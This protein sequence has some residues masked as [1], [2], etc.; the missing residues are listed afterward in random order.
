MIA[1]GDHAK[2]VVDA[3]GKHAEVADTPAVA[4]ERALARTES[5]GWI[6]LKAS[7]GMKLE[8]VLEDMKE[9]TP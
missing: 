1:L 6:L 8:R 9:F 7:R 3:A 4:A 5:G 2:H